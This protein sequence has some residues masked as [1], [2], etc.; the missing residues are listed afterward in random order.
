MGN[1]EY[2][3]H[4][5]SRIELEGIVRSEIA[6]KTMLHVSLQ[7]TPKKKKSNS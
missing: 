5:T 1:E 2:K 3:K 4:E 7:G 6:A